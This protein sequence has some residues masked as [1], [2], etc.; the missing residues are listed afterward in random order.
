MKMKKNLVFRLGLLA[1][2]LTLVTMPLVSGTYAKYVT[3]EV[4]TAQARV[5]KW[6]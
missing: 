3:Q 1:L 2:V 6:G 5:A 4:G